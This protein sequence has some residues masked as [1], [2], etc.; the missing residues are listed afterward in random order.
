MAYDLERINDRA[1]IDP[2]GFVAE[3]DAKYEKN[4]CRAAEQIIGNIA[5]SH[6]VLLSG[7]SGSGKTT[8]AH[9]IERELERRGVNTHTIS[10]DDYYRDVDPLTTPRNAQGEYDFESPELLD[11]PLLAEHFRALDAGEEIVIPHYN[12][13]MRRRDPAGARTLRLSKNE[14]AI[15]EG[16][17]ALNSG[18]TGHGSGENAAKVY[19]SAR[20]NVESAGRTVFKGTWMRILRRV[21]RD[22]RFRSTPAERTFAMWENLRVGEKKYISPYKSRADIV[23]DSSL[24]YEV[25]ALKPFAGGIFDRLPE[26]MPRMREAL[27]LKEALEL[28]EP[29]DA[30]ILPRSSLI[31]EFIGDAGL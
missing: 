7:P 31:R 5:R 15:F 16:I 22:E 18:I 4:V 2:R 11:L 25:C 10:L 20:S 6:L 30:A 12:F 23:F 27:E 8:T 28:F 21:I 14:V 26:G 17:H 1:R 13:D 29:I 24:E 19:I 3:C 9:N